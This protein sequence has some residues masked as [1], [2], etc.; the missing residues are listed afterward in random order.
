MVFS[1]LIK[2]L[3]SGGYINR[4]ILNIIHFPAKPGQMR[5]QPHSGAVFCSCQIIHVLH[6]NKIK[7][8]TQ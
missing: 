1:T 7:L 3:K 2:V 4:L 5:S 6:F 8:I